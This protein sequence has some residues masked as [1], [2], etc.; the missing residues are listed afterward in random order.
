M[1][2]MLARIRRTSCYHRCSHLLCTEDASKI[3]SNDAACSIF[4]QVLSKSLMKLVDIN[5]NDEWI[6]MKMAGISPQIWI[7]LMKSSFRS[8]M[9]S[10]GQKDLEMQ[11]KMNKIVAQCQQK[12]ETM[13]EKFTE[14]LE[15]IHIE[16]QKLA[17]RCQIFEQ[18]IETL[19]EDKQQLLERER[20]RRRRKREL[21]EMYDQA[22][23]EL[24]SLKQ[25]AVQPFNHFYL[26]SGPD[27]FSNPAAMMDSRSST[28]K[29]PREE[30]WAPRQNSSKSGPFDISSGS[31][32]RQTAV[33][34]N[35]GNRMAGVCPPFGVGTRPEAANPTNTMTLKEPSPITNKATSVLLHP[36]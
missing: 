7:L 15:Q 18:E 17:L 33:P 3:L 27:L 30:I 29:L 35:T 26:R 9:F 21:D 8:V 12:C 31:P 36:S 22:R 5:P 23:S 20:E 16:Y 32:A 28:R 19:S 24:E 4:N 11:V 14:K 13:Q 1:Q 6:N 2:C 34:I 25:L 10:T